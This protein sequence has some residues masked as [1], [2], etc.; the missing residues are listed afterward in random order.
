[1]DVQR[2]FRP[3]FNATDVSGNGSEFDHLF[4]DGEHLRSSAL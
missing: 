2:I 4:K 3:V 1:M